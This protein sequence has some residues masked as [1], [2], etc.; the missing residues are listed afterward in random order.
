MKKSNRQQIEN[1]IATNLHFAAQRKNLQAALEAKLSPIRAIY[2]EARRNA[3]QEFAD[4]LRECEEKISSSS[5]VVQQILMEE[6]RDLISC[7]QGRARLAQDV[8]R[9]IEPADFLRVAPGGTECLSV[10]IAKAEKYLSADVFAAIVKNVSKG[11]PKLVIE[12]H[13]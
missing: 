7:A 6:K 4:D 3:E 13:E 12:A 8:V 9:Q 2:E 11:K 10:L 5:A 1:A